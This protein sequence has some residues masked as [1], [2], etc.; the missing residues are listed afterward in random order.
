MSRMSPSTE[1]WSC[2]LPERRKAMKKALISLMIV[3]IIGILLL[4]YVIPAPAAAPEK[5]L[6]VGVGEEPVSM[7][8]SLSFGGGSLVTT[9]NWGEYLVQRTTSGDLKPGL[10]STWKMSP[11]GKVIDFALRKGVKFHS[12]DPMTVKD[13]VFSFERAREKN[14]TTRTRLSLVERIEVIDDYQF[15]M[16][17]K[18]PDVTFIPTLGGMFAVVS[19]AYYDRVG[20]D[21]FIKEPSATGPYKVVRYVPGEYLDLERFEDYWGPKPPVKEARFYFVRE[22]TTKIAKLKAGE[23]DIVN[24][25]PYPSV[26]DIEKTPGLRVVRFENNHPTPSIIFN[27]RNPKVPWHD[28]RVRLAM[29]YAIDSDTIVKSVLLGLPNRYAFLAPYELGYD[30]TLK[31]YPYDPKKA[32][33]LL[34][35]A[36]YPKGF[37]L[38]INW[39]VTGRF[40]MGRETVEA[41]AAYLEAVGIRVKLVAEEYAAWYATNRASKGPEA[42]YVGFWMGGRA[43]SVEP[44]YNLDLFFSSKG[45]FSMYSNPELD[46]I[47]AEAKATVDDKKRAELIKKGTRIVCED[48]ATIPI[49]NTVTFYGMKKN[50]DFLPTQKYNQDLMLVKDVTMK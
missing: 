39:I 34:A 21:K 6:L 17:F 46:K 38:K 19:K 3:S 26:K 44:A 15:K 28:R 24:G 25:C 10:C 31:P 8:P 42:E 13:I 2:V 4:T 11:D 43:G 29:A 1:R 37:E 18:T 23:V 14:P 40:Q 47:I 50:I 35:E 41:I 9:D 7:D 22:D 5:K 27:A 45:G 20:E 30:A 48:V 32:R 36:G 16:H 49:Y 33:E 12:G